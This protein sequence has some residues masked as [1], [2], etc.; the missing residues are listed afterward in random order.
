MEVGPSVLAHSDWR[1]IWRTAVV[2]L[3]GD[4]CGLGARWRLCAAVLLAL[5]FLHFLG[6]TDCGARYFSTRASP[7]PL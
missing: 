5:S 2:P 3:L 4:S 6:R 7:N 1:L